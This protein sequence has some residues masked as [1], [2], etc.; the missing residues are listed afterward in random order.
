MGEQYRYTVQQREH[1]W[2]KWHY[3]Y[4]GRYP[5]LFTL[6]ELIELHLI[7]LEEMDKY[8]RGDSDNVD[9]II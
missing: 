6:A 2:N 4:D 8:F 5:R 3:I 1:W 9:V 7:S